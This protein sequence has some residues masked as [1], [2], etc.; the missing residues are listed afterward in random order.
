MDGCAV[1]LPDES[2]LV[3]LLQAPAQRAFKKPMSPWVLMLEHSAV[4]AGH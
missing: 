1:I 4:Y 2:L 3:P